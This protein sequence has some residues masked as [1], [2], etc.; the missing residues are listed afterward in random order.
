VTPIIFDTTDE[1]LLYPSGYSNFFA[2]GFGWRRTAAGDLELIG[3]TRYPYAI[4]GVAAID[5][6]SHS[7]LVWD[8]S[9]GFGGE[10]RKPPCVGLKALMIDPQFRADWGDPA[11]LADSIF[12]FRT[13]DFRD[14][15]TPFPTYPNLEQSY[16]WSRDEF[17][18]TNVTTRPTPIVPQTLPGGDPVIEPMWRYHARFDWLDEMH[19]QRGDPGWPENVY[20]P[21]ELVERCGTAALAPGGGTVVNGVP[22]GF[23]SHKTEATKPSHRPDVYWGF[24]PS[25][26]ERTRMR[27]AIRW[28]LDELFGLTLAP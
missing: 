25:R 3:P 18:D 11:A 23:I 6:A 8:G 24:D 1:Y 12:T 16:T 19:A 26:F 9:P 5:A 20:T 17:Y 7:Y 14:Y 21:A 10:A 27:S 22:C 15:Q 4:A 2:A 13:I 28:V